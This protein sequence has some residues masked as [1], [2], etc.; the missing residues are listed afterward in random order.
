VSEKDVKPEEVAGDERI[1]A[2][3]LCLSVLAYCFES[4]L[5]CGVHIESQTIRID[6]AFRLLTIVKDD[7]TDP[8]EVIMQLESFLELCR[9]SNFRK[10]IR[11]ES[12]NY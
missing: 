11:T 10:Y 9:K 6:L 3:K 5:R 2:H 12:Q 8:L 4:L 1:P 7:D